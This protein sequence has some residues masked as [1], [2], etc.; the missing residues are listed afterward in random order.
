LEHDA[1]YLEALARATRV[2][3]GVAVVEG[4]APTRWHP[5]GVK[6]AKRHDI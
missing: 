5:A 1:S 6:A 2:A 3:P 4:L